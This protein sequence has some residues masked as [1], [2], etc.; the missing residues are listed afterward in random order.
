MDTSFLDD[1]PVED[2][3]LTYKMFDALAPFDNTINSDTVVASLLENYNAGESYVIAGKWKELFE[4][5]EGK[6]KSKALNNSGAKI[7]EIILGG[8]VVA[9]LEERGLP[10]KFEY[11]DPILES[12]KQQFEQLKKDIKERETF[13]QSLKSEVADTVTGLIIKP[14]VK[15]ATG[16][17]VVRK[18]K[19]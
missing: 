3:A 13:L 12:Y 19:E 7:Q 6:V 4:E 2:F 18:Y 9:T 1:E 17:T 5:A 15:I 16:V 8:K 11:D 10:K 14:A